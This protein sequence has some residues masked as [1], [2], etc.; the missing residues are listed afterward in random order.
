M[1]ENLLLNIIEKKENIY[2]YLIPLFSKLNSE[3]KR[4]SF[5]AIKRIL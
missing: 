5:T 2:L 4:K 3:C 1:P